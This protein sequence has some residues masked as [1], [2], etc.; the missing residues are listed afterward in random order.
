MNFLKKIF[1]S[2]QEIDLNKEEQA[3]IIDTYKKEIPLKINELVRSFAYKKNF[4]DKDLK[5]LVRAEIDE[6]VISN[7]IS[8]APR[9]KYKNLPM[10]TWEASYVNGFNIGCYGDG[11]LLGFNCEYFNKVEHAQVYL[12]EKK[13]LDGIKPTELAES[14]MWSCLGGNYI[15]K[16]QFHEHYMK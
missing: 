15:T 7:F 11:Y 6:N 12:T 3:V 13:D 4:T 5:V 9:F 16:N 2:T 8:G 1:S 10:L 14:L